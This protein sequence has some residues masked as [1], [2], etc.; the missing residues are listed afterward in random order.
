MRVIL[1]IIFTLFS[2]TVLF[3][4]TSQEVVDMS[5]II[6]RLKLNVKYATADNFTERKLYTIGKA[7]GTIPAANSLRIINDSLAKDGLGIMIFD[8][9][10]PRTVQYVLWEIFPVPGFV[11]NPATG[12]IHN[13]GAAIDLT[14]CDLATGEE[15]AMPTPF[16]DFT[17]KA[18]H[19]YQDLPEEVIKNRD[20]LKNIMKRNGFT[21]N[22]MEWW[23]YEHTVSLNYGLKDFQMR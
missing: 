23:H 3:S 22:N 6:P 8:G 9:Y 12:S 10:R 14:L 4:Q 15:L 19:A 1:V 17:D 2:F 18:G 5:E 20:F 11:A 21:E 13:R 7:F 16:D